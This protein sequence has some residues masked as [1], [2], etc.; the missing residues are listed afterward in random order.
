[1][2]AGAGDRAARYVR[3]PGRGWP[4]V[5]PGPGMNNAWI[6]SVVSIPHVRSSARGGVSQKLLERGAALLGQLERGQDG[7]SDATSASLETTC[8]DLI[9]SRCALL[10]CMSPKVAQSSHA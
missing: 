8:G 2:P 5:G 4:R 1:M 3:D 10:Q 9:K 7:I 6:I